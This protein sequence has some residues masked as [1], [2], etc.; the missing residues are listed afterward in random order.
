MQEGG[1]MIAFVLLKS[2]FNNKIL[3][4]LYL[5]FWVVVIISSW[6]FWGEMSFL[7]KFF[8]VVMEIIFIPDIS[9]IKKIYRDGSG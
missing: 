6:M 8:I 4:S 5:F 2:K 7:L 1:G 9:F 3:I